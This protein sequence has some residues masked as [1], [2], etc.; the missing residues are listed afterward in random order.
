MKTILITG[1]SRGIGKAIAKLAAERGYKVIVHGRTDSEELNQAHKE[2]QG[3]VKTIFDISDKQA[4]QGAVAKLGHI[5]VLVNNAGIG[6][7]G[8][9]D[10]A[11]VDDENALAEYRVNVLGTLHAIQAVVPSM[12]EHGSGSIVN[13]ASIRGHSDLT[14]MNTL[15]YSISKAGVIGL[16]KALAKTYPK[17]RINSVSPGFT[18]TEMLEN[19]SE[20]KLAKV[21]ASVIVNRLAQPEEIANMILFLAS[22][23]ASYITGTDFL[24]DGGYS[25]KDK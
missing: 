7:G 23:E 14:S 18:A 25:I 6:Q 1:S 5:D 9:K 10:V 24:V 19:W 17:L 3:S 21:K 2:T 13:I 16:T 12:L 4:T 8:I 20:E 11:D 22:D 15:T